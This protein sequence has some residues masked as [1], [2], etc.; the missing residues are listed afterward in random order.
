MQI[1]IYIPEE[2]GQKLQTEWGNLSRKALELIAIQAYREEVMTSAEVQELLDF[3]SRW[4]TEEF[5]QSSRA[6]LNY[7]ES[8]LE[9]DIENIE[10]LLST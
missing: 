6:Y 10:T 4:E 9:E 2:I 1:T 8:D 3:S 7:T 5:L